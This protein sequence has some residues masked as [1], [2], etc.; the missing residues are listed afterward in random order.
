MSD[1]EI[2]S[3]LANKTGEIIHVFNDGVQNSWRGLVIFEN[4]EKPSFVES[5][6]SP[7]NIGDKISMLGRV[8]EP[9]NIDLQNTVI[10]KNTLDARIE[11]FRHQKTLDIIAHGPKEFFID[12]Q[13]ILD[14]EMNANSILWN[15]EV[16]P[17]DKEWI[18]SLISDMGFNKFNISSPSISR[19]LELDKMTIPYETSI[20]E[21]QYWDSLSSSDFLPGFLPSPSDFR[22]LMLSEYLASC[23]L[24]EIKQDHSTEMAGVLGTLLYLW[25]E[26]DKN[27]VDFKMSAESLNPSNNISLLKHYAIKEYQGMKDINPENLYNIGQQVINKWSLTSSENAVKD[28]IIKTFNELNPDWTYKKSSE[29]SS[30]LNGFSKLLIKEKAFRDIPMITRKKI[31]LNLDYMGYMIKKNI[32]SPG[33][34]MDSSKLTYVSRL[35]AQ[36]IESSLRDLESN[37][38]NSSTLKLFKNARMFI[39]NMKTEGKN[40]NYQTDIISNIIRDFNNKTTWDELNKQSNF[41]SFMRKNIG[42]PLLIGLNSF[43]NNLLTSSTIEENIW[44]AIQQDYYKELKEQKKNIQNLIQNKDGMSS[45]QNLSIIEDVP[46]ARLRKWGKKANDF[47]ILNYSLSHLE[48]DLTDSEVSQYNKSLR[49]IKDISYSIYM[50]KKYHDFL[51]KID[52]PY[53]DLSFA[54]NGLVNINILKTRNPLDLQSYEGLRQGIEYINNPDV[55]KNYRHQLY[56]EGANDPNALCLHIDGF[57]ESVDWDKISSLQDATL[58][59]LKLSSEDLAYKNIQNATF[60]NCDFSE[61]DGTHV[62]FSTCEV[63]E[64]KGLNPTMNL[65]QASVVNSTY[66]DTPQTVQERLKTATLDGENR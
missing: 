2:T 62:D 11:S 29:I 12:M 50:D 32:L 25:K 10:S 58:E 54:I 13:V 34:L 55:I 61:L 31:A 23:Y 20:T 39:E 65:E 7:G 33:D 1:N 24:Q 42:L 18:N 17:H 36:Q 5:E 4:E 28:K 53:G 22:Q 3:K 27:A 48:R 38:L 63:V 37:D 52:N 59:N 43:K 46:M 40:K 64:C 6:L 45:H 15:I 26:G 44:G 9:F 21:M 16:S 57:E 47:N 8:E 60:Q 66:S 35:Y 49:E 19:V 51:E 30:L 41:V 14:Q 56:L